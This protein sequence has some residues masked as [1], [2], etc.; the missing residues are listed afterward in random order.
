ME[1]SSE[2]GKDNASGEDVVEVSDDVVGVVK[3]D[4]KGGVGED[5]SS[6]APDCEEEDKPNCSKERCF[7]AGVGAMEGCDSTKNFYPSWDGN[8]Y[9]SGGKVSTGVYVYSNREHVVAPYD[10]A[11]EPNR[12]Y[13]INYS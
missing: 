8:N 4:V 2:E 1:E 5:D 6:D 7:E 9:S 10:E 11:Q 13:S 3:C 12:E